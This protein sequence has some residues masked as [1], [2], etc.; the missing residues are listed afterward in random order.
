MDPDMTTV[1]LSTNMCPE[2]RRTLINDLK[3]KLAERKNVIC[4][5]TQM[6]E[7]GVDISFPCVIRSLAG[8]D[9]AAQA[10]GR[11]NRNGEYGKYC[12]VYLVN[13]CEEKLGSLSAIKTA[14]DVSRQIIENGYCK[15]LA[16]IEAMELY[17]QKYYMERS[18][19]LNYNVED[20]GLKT[21]MVNL[22]SLNQYR[23]PQKKSYR[24][25]AFKTAGERFQIID[26]PAVSVVVP[27]NDEAKELIARLRA[28]I[29][30][31]EMIGVLRKT[32]KYAVGLYDQT[33]QKLQDENAL[34]LLQCGVWVLEEE[35]YDQESGVVL[36]GKTMDLLMF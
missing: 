6:I 22:L 4:V 3:K 28:G 5:T 9:N 18:D 15:D 24:V 16:S 20:I 34:E 30:D 13:L 1:H 14:Q 21:D 11:C 19:E 2:H 29:S 32:Q 17:F 23:N 7:A 31:Y 33:K 10:A 36:K 8:M 12:S 27:Y 35:Y 25:Q 26:A